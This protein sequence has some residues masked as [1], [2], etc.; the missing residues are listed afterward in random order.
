MFRLLLW[1][2][3]GWYP[4]LYL[5]YAGGVAAVSA[6]NYGT[7]AKILTV[8]V[9]SEPHDDSD[10]KPLTVTVVQ[11]LTDVV[12]AF[13]WLPG[14]E[15]HYVPRSEHLRTRQQPLL[16]DLLFL[17]RSYDRY[18]DRFEILFAL[19]YADLTD[20]DWGPPGRFAWKHSGR[21]GKSP[22]VEL[23]EEAERIGDAWGP[24]QAGLFR[25]SSK[26]FVEV[27][28]AYKQRLDRLAWW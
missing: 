10:L 14:H 7:L 28:D 18:F 25:G 21:R 9:H 1:L 15:R 5:M 11:E 24:L 19:T 13:K 6:E 2:R 4:M 8:P 23:M 17:G 12:E 22:Y 20:R 26:R 3:L 16:E 27:A